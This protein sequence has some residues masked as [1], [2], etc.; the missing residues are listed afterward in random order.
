MDTAA[1]KHDTL[2]HQRRHRAFTPALIA[3]VQKSGG[4]FGGLIYAQ[5]PPAAHPAK[6]LIPENLQ[7]QNR[8]CLRQPLGIEA[9][10]IRREIICRQIPQHSGIIPAAPQAL[11]P[12]YFILYSL[13]FRSLPGK[14]QVHGNLRQGRQLIPQLKNFFRSARSQRLP[15]KP[16][17]ALH[18]RLCKKTRRLRNRTLKHFRSKGLQINLAILL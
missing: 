10:L 18:K 9:E 3:Q 13:S 1:V 15:S 17:S 7:G 14:H 5:N 8:L 16:V 4:G 2:S 12:C 11:T 6:L